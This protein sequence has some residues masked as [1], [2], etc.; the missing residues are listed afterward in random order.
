MDFGMIQNCIVF[1]FEF[2]IGLELTSC[3]EM[4]KFHMHI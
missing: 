3:N 1:S 2:I 4:C